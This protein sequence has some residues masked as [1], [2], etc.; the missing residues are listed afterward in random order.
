MGWH[1]T[2]ILPISASQVARITDVSHYVQLTM[3][4][5][6]WAKNSL[7][8]KSWRNFTLCSEAEAFQGSQLISKPYLGP[9]GQIL[10]EGTMGRG[11][12]SSQWACQHPHIY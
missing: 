9:V 10:I 12:R 11:P 8:L 4:S 2:E 3:N 1:Q 7:H 5:Y 6:L